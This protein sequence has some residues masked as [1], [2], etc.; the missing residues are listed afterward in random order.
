MGIR[1][2]CPLIA[3]VLT[4]AACG[5]N[6]GPPDDPDEIVTV[7]LETFAPSQV[8]A[9]DTINVTC[10]LHENDITTMVPG[11]ITVVDDSRVAHVSGM[12]QARKVGK[13]AVSCSLP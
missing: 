1:A 5:D 10:T 9:G 11:T 2:L 6:L 12:I 4:L 13:I 3:G 7:E 8:T